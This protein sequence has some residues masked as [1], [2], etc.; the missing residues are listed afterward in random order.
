MR[1]ELFAGARRL[2]GA[3]LRVRRG[4]PTHQAEQREADKKAD[5]A[6]RFAVQQMQTP[7]ALE[8]PPALLNPDAEKQAAF[9]EAVAKLAAEMGV[10]A[11]APAAPAK[12]KVDKMQKNGI[13]R[14]GANTVC[15]KIWAA[16]DAISASQGGAPATIASLVA[17][18]ASAGINSHTI[19][20]QYSRWRHYNGVSGR[21]PT[22]AVN[23]QASPWNVAV[24]KIADQVV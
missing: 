8:T 4:L 17:H 20:T 9:A 18:P 10:V 15:G 19:K 7:A 23:Q 5:A 3:R 14:P 13:T 6:M 1:A 11:P 21:L 2:R 16:A 12:V 22:I 24:S